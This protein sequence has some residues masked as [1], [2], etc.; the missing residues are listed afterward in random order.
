M[1]GFMVQLT[2]V[3]LVPVTFAANCIV[4]RRD[5]VTEAGLTVTDAGG[6]RVIVAVADVLE[7]AALVAVIVTF[8]VAPMLDGAV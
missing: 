7:L 1:L 6:T 3:L 2:P 4:W 5:R 8:W